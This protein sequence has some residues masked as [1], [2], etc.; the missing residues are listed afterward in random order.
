MKVIWAPEAE[1]DR[2]DIWDYIAAD[3]PVAAVHMDELISTAA[4][5]LADFP[6]K[7]KWGKVAG[8]RELAPHENDR[9]VYQ[10]EDDAVWILALVHVARMWP[11]LQD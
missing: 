11:L 7:G 8:T 5:T 1:Q 2:L 4:S 9:F 3:N 10:T 6:G